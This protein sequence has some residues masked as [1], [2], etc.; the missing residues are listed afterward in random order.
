LPRGSACCRRATPSGR[1]HRLSLHDALPICPGGT[2]DIDG[3]G[4][5]MVTLDEIRAQLTG[6]GGQFEVVEDVVDGVPMKVFKDR[7]PNLRVDRKSTRL[8]S[9]HVK[10]S[11]AVFG[12]KKKRRAG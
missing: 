2:G 1:I 11:Y 8:H 5:H 6:P 3:T 4:G 7:F 12:L 10:I 9:S